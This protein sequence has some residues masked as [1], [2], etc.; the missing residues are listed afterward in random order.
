MDSDPTRRGTTSD[1]A[2][3]AALQDEIRRLKG[4]LDKAVKINE[5]MW[6]GVVD[7]KLSS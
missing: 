6:S 7:L 1:G 4:A 2:E 5:K 3:V